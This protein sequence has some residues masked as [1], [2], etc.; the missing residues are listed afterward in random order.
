MHWTLHERHNVENAKAELDSV[1]D[2]LQRQFTIA[3]SGS[4]VRGWVFGESSAQSN[5]SVPNVGEC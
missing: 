3:K 5:G 4:G 2:P 1:N